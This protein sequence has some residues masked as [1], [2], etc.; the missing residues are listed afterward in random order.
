MFLLSRPRP[1]IERVAGSFLN[2]I[3]L[4]L[5]MM[6][7]RKDVGVH[8]WRTGDAALLGLYSH[9]IISMV[10]Q[11]SKAGLMA[12]LGKVTAPVLFA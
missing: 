8:L 12:E 3:Q 10:S 2:D 9:M 7:G 4:R 1:A 11:Y 5:K 6:D